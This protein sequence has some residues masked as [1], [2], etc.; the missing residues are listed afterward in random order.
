MPFEFTVTVPFAGCMTVIFAFVTSVLS[1]ESLAT[2]LMMTDL[3]SSVTLTSATVIGASLAIMNFDSL[4]VDAFTF[5][6]LIT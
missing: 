5:C 1:S 2:T 4:S 3:S 6:N